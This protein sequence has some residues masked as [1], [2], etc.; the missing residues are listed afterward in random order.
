MTN[1]V[2]ADIHGNYDGFKELLKTVNYGDNDTLIIL[3]DIVDGGP[4]TRQ[5]I[6]LALSLPNM[7][8]LKGNHDEWFLKWS[9]GGP[10][11]SIWVDQGGRA[12]LNSYEYNRKKVL[13]THIDMIKDAPYYLI[14][15]NILF[16]H[17]GFLPDVPIET[18]S[19]DLLTWDR[20]IISY[21]KDNI[22]EGYDKVFIGHTST[23]FYGNT[24]TPIRANNLIMCDTGGGWTGKLSLIDIDTLNFW[25]AD[26]VKTREF[27]NLLYNTEWSK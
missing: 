16:V 24:I 9:L 2:I 18:Q 13:K 3:G 1:Y 27:T 23:Q 7:T 8:F 5:C 10:E 11:L 4:K 21:A 12:T 25:S 22:I 6:N 14:K 17:G 26:G 15:N 19:P 20:N